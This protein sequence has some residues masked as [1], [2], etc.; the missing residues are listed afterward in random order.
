MG[1]SRLRLG[2][3]L[4]T[5][6]GEFF[7]ASPAR[8]WARAPAVPRRGPCGPTPHPAVSARSARATD[9]GRAECGLRQAR[10]AGGGSPAEEPAMTAAPRLTLAAFGALAALACASSGTPGSQDV[11]PLPR[12]DR[13]VVAPLN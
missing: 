8:A 13:V 7:C 1:F 5:A 3:R 6:D 11:A 9:R 12:P 2:A 10:P 4:P